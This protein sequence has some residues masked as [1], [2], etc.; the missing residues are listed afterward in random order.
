MSEGD[1]DAVAYRDDA[2]ERLAA[3]H[4]DR[5]LAMVMKHGLSRPDAEAI[6]Q[7]AFKAVIK[8]WQQRRRLIGPER[9]LFTTVKQRMANEFRRQDR[10]PVDLVD[11]NEGITATADA[12]WHTHFAE[13]LIDKVDIANALRELPHRQRGVLVLRFLLDLEITVVA[14]LL[15]CSRNDVNYAQRVGL[16]TMKRSRWLAERKV[17]PEVRQ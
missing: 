10:K 2:V 8:S 9:L 16:D 12:L 1:P 6:V 11:N 15:G 4:G 14:E 5:A 13:R 17:M 7:D 3:L